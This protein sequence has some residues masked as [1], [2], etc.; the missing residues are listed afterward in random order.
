MNFGYKKLAKGNKNLRF[1]GY[2]AIVTLIVLAVLVAGTVL[3][4]QLNL[5]VDLTA[6]RMY[7]PSEATMKV[8][9]SLED[10]VEVYGLFSTGTESY[11]YYSYVINLLEQYAKFG[12]KVSYATVDTLMH[13]DF[14]K[15]YLTEGEEATGISNGT[16]LFRNATNGKYR[17][18]DLYSFY[19]FSDSGTSS[20]PTVD[21][22]AAEEAATAAIVY[23]TSD[24][25]PML[26]QLTG[27]GEK[28][29]DDTFL[30]YMNTTNYDF[31]SVNLMTFG[32]THIP[33]TTNEAFLINAPTAD[34]R[35]EEY[36]MLLDYMEH[37]GRMM[38][39]LDA[40]TP[41]ELPNLSKLL[42]R[43]ALG[44]DANQTCVCE[45]SMNYYYGNW[46]YLIMPSV[47]DENVITKGL[48]TGNN[49]FLMPY[50]IPLTVGDKVS[51]YTVVTPFLSSSNSSFLSDNDE[52]YGPFVLGAAVSE[53]KTVDGKMA[54]TRLVVFGNS[55][56]VDATNYG[57]LTTVGNY[58]LVG[59]AMSYLQDEVESIYI[60]SKSLTPNTI[61]PS[62]SSF[63]YGFGAFALL[64]PLAALAI[65]IIVWVR[66][67]H[68]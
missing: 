2:A 54:E 6:N 65:G 32:G 25:V 23:V 59:C 36:T 53:N 55:A 5:T 66:R 35:D 22:F 1:G 13:P 26:H 4:E 38:I 41:D 42:A 62:I 15:Q 52:A 17:M 46:N 57:G 44:Y 33:V 27:H 12:D 45:A 8:L 14:V 43:F 60:S 39:F 50:A 21:A 7:T 47:T 18:L 40:A 51:Q 67:K 48:G 19:E 61:T 56:F 37:G 34:L 58:K 20:G 16:F 11:Q 31:D 10:E 28:A 9:D 29:L 68:L 63:V 3:F 64:L 49:T 30:Y 24:K